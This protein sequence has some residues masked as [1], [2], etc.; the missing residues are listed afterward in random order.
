MPALVTV[1]LVLFVFYL[2]AKSSPRDS[3]P[4][5]KPVAQRH[6]HR[7]YLAEL[8]DAERL[9]VNYLAKGLDSKNYFLFNNI[10]LPTTYNGSTQ[11]DHIVISKFGIFMIESKDMKGWIW[12]S[13]HQNKWTQTFKTGD[14]YPFPNPLP[15]NAAH[16][17]A[18]AS[19]MPFA[20]AHIQ[21]IVAFSTKSTIKT[22]MPPNVMHTD[23]LVEYIKSFNKPVL[24]ED[25]LHLAIGKLMYMCQTVE[26]TAHE[27][28]SNI[29][30]YKKTLTKY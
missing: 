18:I 20:S 17:R 10:I 16:V 28:I 14:K 30:S 21:N 27:H 1:G 3:S 2:L 26:I 22:S 11:I 13:E 19:L 12:G 5:P 8:N 6:G 25:Q 15:Q 4:R 23:E 9:V 24:S 7:C 29:D